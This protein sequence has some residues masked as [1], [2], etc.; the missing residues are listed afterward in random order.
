MP[1]GPRISR[2]YSAAVFITSSMSGGV[3]GTGREL[4]AGGGLGQR[5]DEA[6]EVARLGDQEEPRHLGAHD[7]RVRDVARPEDERA[8]RCDDGSRRRP[9]S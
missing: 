5:A 8:G 2:P 9:R 6:R 4:R 7:E 3:G 1:G